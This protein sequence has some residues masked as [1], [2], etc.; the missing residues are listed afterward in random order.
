MSP[1]K[2]SPRNAKSQRARGIV[3]LPVDLGKEYEVEVTEMSPNGEGIAR[4]KGFIIFVA[5][6]KPG[7]HAKVK[8]TRLDTVSADAEIVATM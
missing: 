6:A 2:K 3:K 4:I 8:I 5:N 1:K 7:N